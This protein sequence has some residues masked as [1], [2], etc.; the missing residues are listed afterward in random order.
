MAK[1]GVAMSGG[2]HRA[3]AWGL[4]SL[5][6]LTDLGLNPGIVSISSVSGGSIANGVAAH[7]G[8]FASTDTA[9]FEEIIRPVGR[10]MASEGLFFFGPATNGWLHR[11][12]FTTGLF[13]DLALALVI[14]TL[15]AGREWESVWWLGLGVLLGVVG[16]AVASKLPTPFRATLAAVLVLAGP[17][18]A[19]AVAVTTG[20]SRLLTAVALVGLLVL[21][22]LAF[23]IAF[24]VFARRS[25]VTEKAMARTHFRGPEGHATL[26]NQVDG[27][28]HH[29]FCASELQ[30]G[31]HVYFSPRMVYGYRVGRGTPGSMTLATAVQCSACLPGAF[32]PRTL[33]TEGFA[34]TRPWEVDENKPPTVPDRIVVNDGGVYDN[35]A[36]QWEQGLGRRLARVGSVQEPADELVV[37][38][39][40]KALDWTPYPESSLG[41]EVGGLARTVDILYDVSTSHRRSAMIA[42]FMASAKLGTGLRGALVHIAQSPYD[43]PMSFKDAH[44]EAGVRARVALVALAT[45]KRSEKGWEELAQ[46]NAKVPTTLS[47]LTVSV[48]ADLLE[49]A[50]VL[51]VINLYVILGYGEQVVA[52]L[53]SRA[54]RERFEA[55]CR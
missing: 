20:A 28:V 44:D 4:G 19:A 38:N 51:T 53:A 31:D 39:A 36:D 27:R 23:V 29:V 54:A 32:S 41:N 3:T 49:H 34:L 22:V 5:L 37:V 7:Q 15:A 24:R 21:T 11:F 43:V 13:V 47:A 33:P 42:R 6:A 30:S 17:L 16:W 55:L 18:T 2:G 14:A 25:L 9:T 26:L 8:D 12:F 40:S 45:L 1:I 46:A 35:M 10:H 52:D 50:W 48:T